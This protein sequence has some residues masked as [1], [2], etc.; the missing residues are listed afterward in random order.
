MKDFLKGYI[1]ALAMQVSHSTEPYKTD[2]ELNFCRIPTQDGDLCFVI[3]RGISPIDGKIPFA[4]NNWNE[5]TVDIYKGWNET[6]W[7]KIKTKYEL[8]EINE[9]RVSLNEIVT[10]LNWLNIDK[11]K[12][13]IKEKLKEIKKQFPNITFKYEQTI[14]V[15]K[16][17]VT[18]VELFDSDDYIEVEEKLSNEFEELFPNEEILFISDNSLTEIEN[19]EFEI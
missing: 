16:I 2:S 3:N 5:S 11:S 1:T 13:F 8:I 15:N 4:L 19:V 7:E 6:I 10:L 12:Q 9:L 14:D 17:K 18:P